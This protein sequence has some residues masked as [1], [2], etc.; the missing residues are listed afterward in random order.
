M[1]TIYD[2][3]EVEENASKEEIEKS[4]QNL[5]LEYQI[6]PNLTDQENKENEM[7]LNKLKIAY[8]ILM[9]DDKRTKYDKSLSQKKAE[10]LLKNVS[11]TS[12]KEVE[13][14]EDN[15]KVDNNSNNVNSR[16][17]T[18]IENKENNYYEDEADDNEVVL[19]Q[20]DQ[21]KIKK[22]AK[23]DFKNNLKKAQ[24]MEEEYN[25]AYTKAYNDYLRKAGYK[26]KEPLTL[27]RLLRTI[28]TIIVI[29]FVFWILWIIPPIHKV[30][31]NI[32]EDNFIIKSL[33]DIFKII[34]QSIFSIFK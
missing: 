33:V 5:L 13:V 6:N 7:I 4:Y 23:R 14:K 15:L 10:E 21:A 32:Y 17:K 26:V 12:D 20:E 31:V 3:L 8:E 30:L 25:Q 9:D 34:F 19:S 28:I 16:E 18:S 29:I 1:V 24:K 2:L 11:T 22:A 27:K